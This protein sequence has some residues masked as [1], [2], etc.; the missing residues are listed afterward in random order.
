MGD[1]SSRLTFS[2]G[3]IDGL[4]T[5][6]AFEHPPYMEIICCLLQQTTITTACNRA[7]EG[8]PLG[9]VRCGV[10]ESARSPYAQKTPRGVHRRP[11]RDTLSL[12]F[13]SFLSAS[14]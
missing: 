11:R 9:R 3:A 8:T 7:R 5:T 12:V 1:R 13:P 10:L 6:L 2:F 4:A 14:D